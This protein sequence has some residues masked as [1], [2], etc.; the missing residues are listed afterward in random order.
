MFLAQE[1]SASILRVG[2]WQSKA[3]KMREIKR[4]DQEGLERRQYVEH[5]EQKEVLPNVGGE[6]VPTWR[7]AKE[8]AKEKGFDSSTYNEKIAEERLENG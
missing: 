1:A 6:A 8:L 4:R 3:L 7:D 2:G 5:G